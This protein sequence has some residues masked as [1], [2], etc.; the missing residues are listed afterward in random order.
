MS[1][2]QS[3]V[4][5]NSDLRSKN[6]NFKKEKAALNNQLKNKESELLKMKEKIDNHKKEL[7]TFSKQRDDAVSEHECSNFKEKTK[8]QEQKK[9]NS[10]VG[11]LNDSKIKELEARLSQEISLNQYLNKRISGN[12]VE[13]N[14]SS[15]RRSTSYSDDPLD[16]E[17]I[18]KKYYDLQ[19]TF[20][21]ITGNLENEIEEKKNLVSRLRFT[22]TRLA[23]SS[24]EDQR[25]RH[26]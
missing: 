5:E 7:A 24:F 10:L 18:I 4:T 26:K 23:S 6:E 16:K 25:L 12:S 2:L 20:T 22:E 17:D 14:I 21:Q 11:S 13:T 8:E 9:R 15:T 1:R 3:L 19:L